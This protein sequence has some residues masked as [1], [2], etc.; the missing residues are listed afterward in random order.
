MH[1]LAGKPN[2]NPKALLV[3]K[4]RTTKILRINKVPGPI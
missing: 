3:Q 2:T 1:P 4:T